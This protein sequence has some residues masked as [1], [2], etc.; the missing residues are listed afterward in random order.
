MFSISL[1]SVSQRSF[2]HSFFKFSEYLYDHF[3]KICQA[4]YLSPFHLDLLQWFCPVLFWGAYSSDSSFYLT[5]YVCF[6]VLGKSATSPSL[7]SSDL[8]NKRSCRA[9]Q[10]NV[11]F[12]PESGASGVSPVC[13]VCTL[14][15][16]LSCS[17]LQPCH[18][19]WLSACCKQSF[20]PVS[21]VGQSGAA[22]GLSWVKLGV[23]QRCMQ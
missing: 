23:C 18:L 12:S 4:S 13:A 19:Q 8:I 14:L 3:L 7:E 15:L 17:C 5:P 1:L 11:P 21:L 16:W 9:L 10:C 20:V 22:L 2:L 6:Y